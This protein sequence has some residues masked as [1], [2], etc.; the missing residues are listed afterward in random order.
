MQALS[1]ARMKK[2]MITP[3]EFADQIGRP[4]ATVMRWLREGLVPGV[5]VKQESRGPVYSVPADAVDKLESIEPPKGRPRKP[6]SELKH[7]R[8]KR[9]DGK[10]K[11]TVN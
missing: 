11:P 9:R 10:K 2:P 4:Y 7:P 1:F 8:R 3:Q 6:E 5:K